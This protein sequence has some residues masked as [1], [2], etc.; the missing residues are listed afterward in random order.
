MA[1]IIYLQKGQK[2]PRGLRHLLIQE[3]SDRS[4]ATIESGPNGSRIRVNSFEFDAQLEGLLKKFSNVTEPI[5]V[6]RL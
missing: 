2:P 3:I 6:L 4:Q 1:D 5:Y